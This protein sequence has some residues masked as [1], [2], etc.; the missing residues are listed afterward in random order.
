MS[1]LDDKKK[2]NKSC[3][4]HKQR[5]NYK[6]ELLHQCH[7][8]GSDMTAAVLVFVTVFITQPPT[9]FKRPG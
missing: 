2:K 8:P 6:T 4:C 3:P 1:L 7:R 9:R 5:E